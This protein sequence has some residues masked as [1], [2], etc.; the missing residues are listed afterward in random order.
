MSKIQINAIV[1]AVLCVFWLTVARRVSVSSVGGKIVESFN[2]IPLKIGDWRSS[3]EKSEVTSTDK[4]LATCSVLNREYTNSSGDIGVL[5]IV[6]GTSL[7]DLHQPEICLGGQGWSIT[8][9]RK[10]TLRPKGKSSFPVMM[11]RMLNDDVGKEQVALYWFESKEGKT[12]LLPSHKIRVYL[13]RF[14]GG[15]VEGSALIRILV[16]LVGDDAEAEAA[17]TDLARAASP[18]IETMLAKPPHI[19]K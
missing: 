11:S 9:Q 10:T 6:Y 7:G 2:A 16:P 12:T 4:R 15:S 13:A 1:L 14:R 19:V 17:A 3:P 8:S 18:Y 5:T